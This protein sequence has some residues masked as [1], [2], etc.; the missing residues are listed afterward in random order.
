MVSN[1]LDLIQ[2]L[3]ECRVVVILRDE[4]KV[5]SEC[6]VAVSKHDPKRA[7]FSDHTFLSRVTLTRFLAKSSGLNDVR[8]QPKK[9]N[10]P[11]ILVSAAV[12]QVTFT[13]CSMVLAFTFVEQIG[14]KQGAILAKKKLLMGQFACSDV[15]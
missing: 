10:I 7:A 3:G 6:R 2:G 1:F 15:E 14:D 8:Q 12:I 11:G 9:K 5:T 13:R 4:N